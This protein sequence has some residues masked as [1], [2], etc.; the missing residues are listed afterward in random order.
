MFHMLEHQA[1]RTVQ[2]KHWLLKTPIYQRLW[3]NFFADE[4]PI[5]V[6]TEQLIESL[7]ST[8]RLLRDAECVRLGPRAS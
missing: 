7:L 5:E 6:W 8:G 3:G 2:L 1:V 4:G